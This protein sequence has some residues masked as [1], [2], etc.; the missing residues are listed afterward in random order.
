MITPASH[1][2]VRLF[3]HYKRRIMPMAGG[4]F[5]QPNYYVEAMEI[6][7]ERD[8]LIQSEMA[9]RARRNRL[10]ADASIVGDDA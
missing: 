8:A 3:Q 9:E 4:L 1:L 2:L 6:L 10:P 7:S 5:D